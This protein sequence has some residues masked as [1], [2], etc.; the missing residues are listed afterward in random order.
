MSGTKTVRQLGRCVW[1]EDGKAVGA[2]CLA[3]KKVRQVGRC[4]WHRR[5][6]GRWGVVSDI[7]TNIVLPM[8]LKI[9]FTNIFRG[10][11]F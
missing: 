1:H 10:S 7:Y 5:R 4:V 9:S 11:R 8:M 2:L 6:Q 3:Q